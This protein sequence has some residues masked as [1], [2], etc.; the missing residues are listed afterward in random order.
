MTPEESKDF[1]DYGCAARCIIYLAHEN[2]ISLTIED[3]VK[4][5]DSLFKSDQGRKR[6]GLITPRDAKFIC[7]DLGIAATTQ[8]FCI[9]LSFRT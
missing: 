1:A 5:Y 7:V 3:F 2:G 8:C 4:K 6:V 9:S